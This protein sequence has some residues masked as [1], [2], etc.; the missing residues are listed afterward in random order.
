MDHF[1]KATDGLLRAR[2]GGTLHRNFQGYTTHGDCELIA[3]GVSAIS[4]VG[5]AYAQNAKDLNGYYEAIDNGKLATDRGYYL[6]NDDEVV[7]DVIQQLMCTYNLNVKDINARHGVDFWRFFENA[8][9]PL[10]HMAAEGLIELD[11]G[12]I[13]VTPAGRFLIRNIC[14]VFDAYVTPEASGFSKT[15]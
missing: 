2:G 4:K 8:W 5:R 14:M 13:H 12:G 7:A 3:M 6:T 1:A 10:V 9:T 11:E 15:L